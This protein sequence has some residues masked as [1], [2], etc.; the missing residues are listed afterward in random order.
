[1]GKLS[2][3]SLL[4]LV[5]LML[6]ISGCGIEKLAALIENARTLRELGSRQVESAVIPVGKGDK[7]TQRPDVLM[8]N[9]RLDPPPIECYLSYAYRTEDRWQVRWE[10]SLGSDI[11]GHTDVTTLVDRARAYVIVG[12]TVQAL[13][14]SDGNVEWE[15]SLSDEIAA[16]CRECAALA[17]DRLV[18]LASD[19]VLQ[20]VDVDSGEVV[21]SHELKTSL[22]WQVKPIVLDGGEKVA[23]VDQTDSDVAAP[24][25]LYVFGARDGKQL[26]SV[27]PQCADIPFRVGLPVFIDKR[28]ENVYFTL[29]LNTK[30]CIQGWNIDEGKLL[31]ENRLPKEISEGP[32]FFNNPHLDSAGLLADDTLYYGSGGPAKAGK[33]IDIDLADGAINLLLEDSRYAIR[34]LL[35]DDGTLLVQASRTKGSERHELWGVDVPS[36]ERL[37]RYELQ[38]I[39]LIGWGSSSFGAGTWTIAPVGDKL[40]V[41]QVISEGDQALLDYA[42]VDIL[43]IEDGTIAIETKT[44]I[45]DDHWM[46]T[47]L[48]KDR[49]YLSIRNLY[50]VNLE[51]GIVNWEWPLSASPADLIDPVGE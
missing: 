51:T 36:G 28:G 26:R 21:W 40:A 14:L 6:T 29:S 13:R 11:T 22:D 18:V 8:L 2:K 17:E 23:I 12:P 24:G 32:L 38:A 27:I 5:T 31:W 39:D 1:M 41:I 19:L 16:T 43:E 3:I 10:H 33:L 46:G 35:R 9:R 48:T 20:G 34:P 4:A 45:G 50:S 30:H 37:W 15:A 47:A 25:G 42:V 49:A 7:E 44:L